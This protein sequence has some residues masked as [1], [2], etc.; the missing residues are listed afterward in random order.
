TDSFHGPRAAYIFRR[1][2]LAVTV[3]TVRPEAP[4]LRWRIAH[5]REAAALP[6]TMLRVEARRLLISG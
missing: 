2:G 6:W 4:G 1:F 3:D 5:L